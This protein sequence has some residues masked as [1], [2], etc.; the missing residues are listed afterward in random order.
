MLAKIGFQEF[1]FYYDACSQNPSAQIEPSSVI[2]SCI[3]S[4]ASHPFA[5]THILNQM[6][7][8]ENDD[9]MHIL[10]APILSTLD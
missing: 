1:I 4:L 6:Y 3:E 5:A 2:K 8:E 9:R 10:A 7:K